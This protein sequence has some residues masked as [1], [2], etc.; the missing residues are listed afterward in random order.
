MSEAF[1]VVK[2]KEGA[3]RECVGEYIWVVVNMM[4]RTWKEV[5]DL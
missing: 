1:C 2:K 5:K 4:K 3:Q